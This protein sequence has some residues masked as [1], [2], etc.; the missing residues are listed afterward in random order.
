MSSWTVQL[1]VLRCGTH[2]SNGEPIRLLAILA[3]HTVVVAVIWI[4]I[5]VH[6]VWGSLVHDMKTCVMT[7]TLATTELLLLLV[8]PVF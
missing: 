5:D 1:E 4:Q 2:H 8:L 7:S 6:R 3:L